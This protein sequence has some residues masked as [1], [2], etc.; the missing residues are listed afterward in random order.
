MHIGS[1]F[2]EIDA[3]SDMT[4]A[5]HAATQAFDDPACEPLELGYA[6]D[7]LRLEPT[8]QGMGKQG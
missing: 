1:M 8:K 6:S 7:I 2:F 5:M 3:G 4:R